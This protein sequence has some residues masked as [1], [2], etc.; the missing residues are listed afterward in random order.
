MPAGAVARLRPDAIRRG[1]TSRT[2]ELPGP[3]LRRC[4]LGLRGEAIEV[5]M[6]LTQAEAEVVELAGQALNQSGAGPP[7]VEQGPDPAHEGGAVM[8]PVHAVRDPLR[9]GVGEHRGRV[10]E[11]NTKLKQR[12]QKEF[13][14]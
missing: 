10:G 2:R 3:R 8:G 1:S 4:L 11:E 14:A 6:A 13:W 9:L 5:R 7:V 12:A